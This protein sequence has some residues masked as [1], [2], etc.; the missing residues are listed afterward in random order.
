MSWPVGKTAR[1]L[2]GHPGYSHQHARASAC[3][4]AGSGCRCRLQSAKRHAHACVNNR[5]CGK[6]GSTHRSLLPAA[7]IGRGLHGPMAGG[8]RMWK[9]R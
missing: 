5:G 7:A 6:K 9:L 2:D 4:C 1:M 8:V 3:A